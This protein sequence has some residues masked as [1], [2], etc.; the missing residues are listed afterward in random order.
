[1]QEE[2]KDSAL[3]EFMAGLGQTNPNPLESADPFAQKVE[4]KTED[5]VEEEEK[6]EKPLPFHK[7]PKILRFIEKEV[8]KRVSTQRPAEQVTTHAADDEGTALL[9]R[10]IGNDTPEKV[11]AVKDF[12]KYLAG[13]EDKGAQK[14]LAKLQE[15]SDQEQEAERKA[16]DQL[17]ES[18]EQVEETYN[19][20]LS[21]NTPQ[22]RKTRSDFVDYI[23]KIAPKNEDGEV[24]SFPDI[25]A[26]FEEF[27]ERNKKAPVAP[28]RAKELASKGIVRSSDATIAP[29]QT[30]KDWKSIDKLFANLT[31]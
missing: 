18:F 7:D 20:D 8:G 3:Q 16:Q 27:Q 1:M 22:A 6:D 5:V 10:I 25:P 13:L 21:S 19:V 4:E 29:A 17:E 14:A 9:E 12:Q 30:K 31:S 15:Q 23:R 11:Q 28:N 24:A 2:K 26:A